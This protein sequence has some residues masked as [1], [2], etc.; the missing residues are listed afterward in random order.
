MMKEYH[1]LVAGLPDLI[2]DISKPGSTLTEFRTYLREELK[3]EDFR[4]VQSYFWRFDNRNLLSILQQKEQDLDPAGNITSEDFDSIFTLVKDDSLHTFEKQVPDYFSTFIRA[5][6]NES[7]VIQG[8][9]WENQLTE[10]YYNYLF[11]QPNDFI[12]NW[13]AYE[14]DLKNILTAYNCKKYDIPTDNQVIGSNE[15]TE[16]LVKSNARDFG[17]SSEFPGIEQILRII[18]EDDLLEREKKIDQLKWDM[19]DE[20]TF[21]YYFTIERIFAYMLKI[22]MIGRWMSLDRITGQE[23]FEKLL[24]NLETSQAFPE[25]FSQKK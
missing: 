15:L 1:C 17:I 14:A 22:E 5:F 21:F 3:E 8:K 9:D 25:E 18:E 13:Y 10:L 23:M 12:A 20:W 6:K 19:L 7:P 24:K 11:S 4:L 2:F 16:K